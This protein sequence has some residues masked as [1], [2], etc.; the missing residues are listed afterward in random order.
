MKGCAI[1]G[2]ALYEQGLQEKDI[3]N[4]YRFIDW[5]MMLPKALAADFW[6]DF[7]QFETK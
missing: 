7:K 2:T 5:V 6:Q 1:D 3:R 4:F